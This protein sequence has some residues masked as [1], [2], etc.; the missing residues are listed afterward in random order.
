MIIEINEK[1]MDG[2]SMRSLYSKMIKY[3]N[4]VIKKGSI[5]FFKLRLTLMVSFV[6]LLLRYV[7]SVGALLVLR[8]ILLTLF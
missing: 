8:M 1:D 3:T 6:R 2:K 7:K 5:N 4:V